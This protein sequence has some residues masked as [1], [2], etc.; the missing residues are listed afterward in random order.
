MAGD[1]SFFWT[2]N[3][4]YSFAK[5]DPDPD[6]VDAVDACMAEVLAGDH[7]STKI[8]FHISSEPQFLFRCGRFGVIYWFPAED[9][10]IID[11]ILWEQWMR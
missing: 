4:T 2:D 8:P 11:I 3:A 5:F 9:A 10:E 1:N 6:E 7:E